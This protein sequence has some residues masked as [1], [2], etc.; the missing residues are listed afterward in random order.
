MFAVEPAQRRHVHVVVMIVAEQDGVDLRQGLEGDPG[1]SDALGTGERQQACPSRPHRISED[2]QTTR[3]DQHAR[4]AND[5]RSQ[6]V[7]MVAR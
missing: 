4:V 7:E 5:R 1:R 3:L 6:A 2:V